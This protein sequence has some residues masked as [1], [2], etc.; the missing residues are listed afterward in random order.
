MISI[1]FIRHGT[2]EW[3]LA[4]KMQ[5]H[6]DIP[7]AEV[8]RVQAKLLAERLISE[9]WDGIIASDLSR[10]R[11]TARI[12]S[13]ITKTPVLGLDARLRERSYGKLEGTTLEDRLLR[14]GEHWR[15]MDLGLENEENLLHRWTAFL[16][17]MEHQYKGKRILLVSHGGYIVPILAQFIGRPLEEHL[18]N[19]S[20]SIMERNGEEWHCSL[21]NCTAHLEEL[22]HCF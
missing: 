11:E 6:R 13:D 19:A 21:L 7:L 15:T 17:E 4:G 12:I 14:W 2:T 8:G 9:K 16:A 3:N 5:G 10:A 20:L 18:K 22:E 1:G